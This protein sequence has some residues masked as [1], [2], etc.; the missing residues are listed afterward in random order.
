MP[1]LPYLSS[2]DICRYHAVLGTVHVFRHPERD[3]HRFGRR[4]PMQLSSQK[5]R[6]EENLVTTYALSLSQTHPRMSQCL[7]SGV[8]S[9][10]AIS[11]VAHR[12]HLWNGSF[13]GFHI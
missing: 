7:S 1:S 13:T 3:E 4:L 8:A 6:R 12:T 9:C 10:A 5:G 2:C 11:R